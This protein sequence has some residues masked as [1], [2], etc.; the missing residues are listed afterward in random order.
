MRKVAL[1][2]CGACLILTA[3]PAVSGGPGEPQIGKILRRA[4]KRAEQLQSL[5]VTEQEEIQLGEAVSEKIRVRY[6]VVQD[7]AVHKYVA[8][9]GT[10]LVENG[11]RPNLPWHVRRARHR[12]GERLRGARRVHPRDAGRARAD[13]R[14]GRAGRRARPR[15]RPRDRQAHGGG[16]PEE[17]RDPDRRQRDLAGPRGVQPGRGQD[18]RDRDGRL[19]PIGG[20]RGR[21]RRPP[22]RERDRV[23]PKGPRR[24]S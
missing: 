18:R 7:A 9:V 15:D 24:L 5:H 4:E 6:G 19:R 1:L 14:R 12:R 11:P 21:P 16:D 13:P 20:A 23:R 17:Q 8:L 3:A 2:A 22:A 10:V